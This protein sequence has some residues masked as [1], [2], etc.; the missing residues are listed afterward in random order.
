MV[1]IK[2]MRWLIPLLVL[3]AILAAPLAGAS[4]DVVAATRTLP[5]N[6]TTERPFNVTIFVDVNESQGLNAVAVEETIPAGW[7]VLSSVPQHLKNANG[8]ITWLLG[9]NISEYPISPLQDTLI[10]YTVRA[11]GAN[12]VFSGMWLTTGENQTIGGDTSIPNL[13]DVGIRKVLLEIEKWVRGEATLADVLGMI[14]LWKSS[15]SG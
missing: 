10:T 8:T 7:I 15:I 13:M 14:S 5:A 1:N 12:G 9:P 3:A 2:F 6:A 4:P 11:T